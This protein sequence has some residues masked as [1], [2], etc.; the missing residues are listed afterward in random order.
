MTYKPQPN[1]VQ[2]TGYVIKQDNDGDGKY[3]IEI[4]NPDQ[5]ELVRKKMID[6]PVF[7]T[8]TGLGDTAVYK[9]M[10]ND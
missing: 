4:P 6:I 5:I 7:V 2:F 9:T 8:V 1:T 3:I 10:R